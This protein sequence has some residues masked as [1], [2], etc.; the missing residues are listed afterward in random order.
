M[1]VDDHSFVAVFS[2]DILIGLN[3]CDLEF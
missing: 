2:G 3:F 1:A